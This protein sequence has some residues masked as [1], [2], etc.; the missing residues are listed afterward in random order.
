MAVQQKLALAFMLVAALT[1]GA[2]FATGLL[3]RHLG[4]GAV[5]LAFFLIMLVALG[6]AVVL[7]R[8]F[9]QRLSALAI[10]ARQISEGDLAVR[11]P[12][13]REVGNNDEI[14]DLARSLAG[15]RGALLRLLSEL[16]DVSEEIHGSAQGLSGTAAS[17]T[18]LTDE[19]AGTAQRLA[20]SSERSV[21]EMHRTLDVT[22]RVDGSARS[23]SNSAEAALALTRRG[24]EDARRGRE[25]AARA[26]AELEHIAYQV[27]RMA[28][29]VEGFQAQALSINKTVDLI[30]TIAQQTHLVALNAAIE[31]ARAGEHGHGFAVVAE[32]VRQ[33]SERAARFA[34]QIAGFAG[35]INAG[36]GV[37]I[38]TM[39]ETTSAARA[40]R[41][42]VAGA[43]DALRE[44]AGGVLPLL[45]QMEAIASASRTQQQATDELVRAI[46]EVTRTIRD[47]AAGTEE[48]SRAT[49][50]EK[51]EME[52]M[53][54]AA[55][56][57]AG[58]SDRLKRL[59]G[60]FRLDRV[61]SHT[62]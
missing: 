11:I 30:A 37:V 17:L 28:S 57:L 26:D 52:A 20:H 9:A 6:A 41:Q 4:M 16:A 42:V 40:G 36:S 62:A 50:R 61:E 5:F 60:V 1:G 31:A 44:I 13:P 25:L 56:S 35:Q 58:T 19:I 59:C 27:D 21:D 32:E 33:L 51:H 10:A 38:A 2:V 53:A 48:T 45:E 39:R 8:F 22:Q 7:S 54:R 34:E 55:A 24:G 49:Q 12:A 23:I 43:N 46:E 14:D 3:D 29:A 15:M 18:T 47:G